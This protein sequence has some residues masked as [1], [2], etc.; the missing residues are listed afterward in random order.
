MFLSLLYCD[1]ECLMM[2]IEIRVIVCVAVDHCKLEIVS[3]FLNFVK[4]TARISLSISQK[5]AIFFFLPH[6]LKI[7]RQDQGRPENYTV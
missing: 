6:F 3:H 2:L 7:L 5:S 4:L 1:V